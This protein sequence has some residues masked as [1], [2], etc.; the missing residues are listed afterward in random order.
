[1][2]QP[3][4]TQRGTTPML[5]RIPTPVLAG[6]AFTPIVLFCIAMATAMPGF[7]DP[8]EGKG[9]LF[10]PGMLFSMTCALS[11]AYY[12]IRQQDEFN[13]AAMKTAW[14]WAALVGAI[15]AAL[16]TLNPS[17]LHPFFATGT[18]EGAAG[19]GDGVTFVIL[20]QAA[21][22]SVFAIIWKVRK[23]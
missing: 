20:T 8:V 21:C 16:F 19:F 17:V 6:L 4:T 5:Q 11:F 7:R 2:T 9:P 23:S 14:F 12:Q 13:T 18:P 3:H 22:A 10:L 1:M 15:I